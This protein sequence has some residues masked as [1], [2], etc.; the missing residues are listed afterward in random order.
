MP[1]QRPQPRR[2]SNRR[3]GSPGSGS[4][5]PRPAANRRPGPAGPP[6]SSARAKLEKVSYPI[7]VRLS[8]LPKWLLGILT[9]GLLLGGLLAPSPWGPAMLGLVTVFLLWLLVLAWPRLSG[10][11][12]LTRAVVVAALAAAVAARA[13][14]V[15]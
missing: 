5:S 4:R 13:A 15:L 1:S 3:P 9:G 10:S 6:P 14:G 8:G 11:A 2:K 7:L 12:R